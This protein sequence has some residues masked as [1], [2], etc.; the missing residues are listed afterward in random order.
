MSSNL[1]RKEDQR[2]MKYYTASEYKS[3]DHTNALSTK[4]CLEGKA[5]DELTL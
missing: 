1:I 2:S 4:V 5:E 3:N